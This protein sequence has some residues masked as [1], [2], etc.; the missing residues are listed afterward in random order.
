MA[1]TSAMDYSE[2]DGRLRLSP[3]DD[4]MG[5]G[6]AILDAVK[7]VS[8][9]GEKLHL[10][11]RLTKATGGTRDHRGLFQP[12]HT[13]ESALEAL[14]TARTAYQGPAIKA[15]PYEIL[16]DGPKTSPKHSAIRQMFVERGL[17]LQDTYPCRLLVAWRITRH[18]ASCWGEF[19]PQDYLIDKFSDI[20]QWSK[21]QSRPSV[22]QWLKHCLD[23]LRLVQVLEKSQSPPFLVPEP[24]NLQEFLDVVEHAAQSLRIREGSPRLPDVGRYGLFGLLD[25]VL[26]QIAWPRPHEILCFESSLIEQVMEGM[27][28]HGPLKLRK[29]I[30]DHYGLTYTELDTLLLLAST[31]IQNIPTYASPQAAKA[32]VVARLEDFI[33]RS[34]VSMMLRDELM[35]LKQLS[36]VLGL[37]KGDEDERSSHSEITAFLQEA[38]KGRKILGEPPNKTRMVEAKVI[39]KE[40][41]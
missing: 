9:T 10:I 15:D 27:T 22:P 7:F 12:S 32:I 17:T 35:A 19:S 6:D 25:P 39:T 16:G 2:E 29:I 40:N 23:T 20:N 36:S 30:K 14:L 24:H 11:H 33:T 31:H 37:L 1:Y 5:D 3:L 41:T 8:S 13:P 34:K 21:P 18:L 4:E 28:Q 38:A 26:V